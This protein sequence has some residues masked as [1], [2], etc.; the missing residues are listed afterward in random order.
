MNDIVET[1]KERKK[2]TFLDSCITGFYVKES[3]INTGERKTHQNV[4]IVPVEVKRYTFELT[5][6]HLLSQVI[7]QLGH[8]S[9]FI[10]L[11]Y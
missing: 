2:P 3:V 11:N 10:Q 4:N 9:L 7:F 5:F 6:T 8:S 1:K